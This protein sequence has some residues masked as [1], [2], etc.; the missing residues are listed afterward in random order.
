M[1]LVNVLGLASKQ[2]IRF[3]ED[4][5]GYARDEYQFFRDGCRCSNKGGGAG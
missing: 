3:S 4:A 1:S 2:S 5:L